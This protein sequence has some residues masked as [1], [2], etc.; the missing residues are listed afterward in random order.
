MAATV[1]A[2][3][4]VV[5]GCAQ[6]ENLKKAAAGLS[7]RPSVTFSPPTVSPRP[8]PTREPATREPEA[9]GSAAA[10]A[11]APAS[12]APESAAPASDTPAGAPEQSS[13]TSALPWLLLGLGVLLVIGVTV[14]IARRSSRRAADAAAWRRRAVDA[15]AKGS[16]LYDMMTIT[17]VPDAWAADDAAIRWAE[18]QRRADD[19]TQDLYL[20]RDTA[21]G[22]LE[23]ARAADVLGA[24]Q[25]ARTAMNAQHAPGGA[26][27]PHAA[28]V[29]I[30]LGSFEQTLRELRSPAEYPL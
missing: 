7:P 4:L 15:S 28:R 25:A 5:A 11:P 27:E 22:D 14:L 8:R 21:P 13:A 16:A 17:E 23:H 3:G 12:A 9:T 2:A 20:L 19:L 29:R 24:L 1:A 10:P 30:L 6:G 18:L 26:S